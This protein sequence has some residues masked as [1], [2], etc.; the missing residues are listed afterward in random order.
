MIP[1]SRLKQTILLTA[2]ALL[3]TSPLAAAIKTKP[4]ATRVKVRSVSSASRTKPSSNAS[5]RTSSHK[6]IKAGSTATSYKGRKGRV[7]TA[8][9]AKPKPRGQQSIDQARTIEIQQALI[10]E[11]YLDGEATGSWDQAT[12]DALARF[13]ADNHWQTKILP[14]SRALIKLGLGPSQERLLNPESAAIA[15]PYQASIGKPSSGGSN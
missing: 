14:D 4:G 12:R 7:Q 6:S 3:C 13:Q 11:R 10:R 5:V 1:F 9:V 15:I 8:S 2:A